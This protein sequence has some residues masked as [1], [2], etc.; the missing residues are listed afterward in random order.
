MVKSLQNRARAATAGGCEKRPIS[1]LLLRIAASRKAIGHIREF[2]GVD[3]AEPRAFSG[4]GS[5]G[6]IRLVGSVFTAS[7]RIRWIANFDDPQDI[8]RYS[9]CRGKR[10]S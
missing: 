6:G 10:G 8:R 3:Q 9:A 7:W 5:F 4:E 1:L 2:V